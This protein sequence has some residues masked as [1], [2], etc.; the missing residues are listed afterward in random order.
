MISSKFPHTLRFRGPQSEKGLGFQGL[1]FRVAN[2]AKLRAARA[3]RLLI[4]NFRN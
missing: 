1:G 4:L 3:E 2:T